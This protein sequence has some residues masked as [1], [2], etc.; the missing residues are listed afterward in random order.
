MRAEIWQG[1]KEVFVLFVDLDVV[2]ASALTSLGARVIET[3]EFESEVEAVAWFENW[4]KDRCPDVEVKLSDQDEL[5]LKA[6][7]LLWPGLLRED[8]SL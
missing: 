4:A 2:E 6:E 1:E 5:E 8:D 3:K 7:R